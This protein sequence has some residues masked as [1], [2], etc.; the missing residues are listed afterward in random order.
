M[1]F[2]THNVSSEKPP[3]IYVGIDDTDT[4]ESRGTGRLARTIAAELATQIRNF[5][6][7]PS[8]TFRSPRH[9]LHIPQQLR[10]NPCPSAT[11][12]MADIFATTKKL[13]LED[14]IEG[15]DPGLAISSTE[16]VTP[17]AVAFGQD[18]KTMIVTQQRALN[19]AH[20]LRHSR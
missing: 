14:F 2:I 8:P 4:L 3:V 9:T 10:R 20:A 1:C 7:H 13:M 17:A 11:S 18:A 16:Q 6:R 5:R 12:A 15:S 19:V